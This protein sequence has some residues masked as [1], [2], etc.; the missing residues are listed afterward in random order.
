M[1]KGISPKLLSRYVEMRQK[2]SEDTDFIYSQVSLLGIFEEAA[3]QRIEVDPVA[4]GHIHRLIENRVLN[5]T[6]KLNDF[7]Y[8]LGADEQL[9]KM[10]Q[11]S[12]DVCQT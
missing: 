10:E 12:M 3:E 7:I 4:L 2:I 6:E 9:K 11:V 8:I 5:I 1:L